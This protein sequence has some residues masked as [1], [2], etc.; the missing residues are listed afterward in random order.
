MLQPI[1]L[2]CQKLDFIHFVDKCELN[3]LTNL[4]VRLRIG[5]LFGMNVHIYVETLLT[6]NSSKV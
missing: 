1:Q 4:N 3:F 6:G 2:Y 5:L